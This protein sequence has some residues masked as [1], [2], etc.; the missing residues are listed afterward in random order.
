MSL[1]S[2][3]EVHLLFQAMSKRIEDRAFDFAFVQARVSA[4]S[5]VRNECALAAS[6][7][8]NPDSYHVHME[9]RTEKILKKKTV[10]LLIVP[11]EDGKEQWNR[12]Y[13]FELKMAWPGAPKGNAP[14]VKKDLAR[15]RERRTSSWVLVLYFAIE[16][17]ADWM[18]YKRCKADFQEGLER[19]ICHLKEEEGEPIFKGNPFHFSDKGVSGDATLLA[20]KA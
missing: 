15:L 3:S 12:A 5:F 19:F 11:I 13:E 17:S 10:D 18:P 8:L 2:D 1:L 4:E 16:S 7:S 9:K 20:W 14:E 6:K